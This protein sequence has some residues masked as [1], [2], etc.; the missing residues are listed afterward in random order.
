[1]N[2]RSFPKRIWHVAVD[3]VH[4]VDQ[5]VKRGFR[6]HAWVEVN[7][8]PQAQSAVAHH[9]GAGNICGGCLLQHVSKLLSNFGKL[10]CCQRGMVLQVQETFHPLYHLRPARTFQERLQRFSCVI[11]GCLALLQ[12]GGFVGNAWIVKKPPLPYLLGRPVLREELQRMHRETHDPSHRGKKVPSS[13]QKLSEGSGRARGAHLDHQPSPRGDQIRQDS[14]EA[15]R[16]R[17]ILEGQEAQFIPG[18]L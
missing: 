17:S 2:L 18:Q 3:E 7:V 4:C 12:T 6:V 10:R 16:S 5:M 11:E 8:T 15:D 13:A 9:L 1:M 14:R